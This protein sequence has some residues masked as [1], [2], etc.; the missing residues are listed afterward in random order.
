M[1]EQLITSS[2]LSQLL[3]VISSQHKHETI[4]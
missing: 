2:K 3:L 1:K 4:S